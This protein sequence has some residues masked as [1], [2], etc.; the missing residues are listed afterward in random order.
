MLPSSARGGG[1]ENCSKEEAPFVWTYQYIITLELIL[2][3]VWGG[4]GYYRGMEPN[5]VKVNQISNLPYLLSVHLA[6]IPRELMTTL[7][8]LQAFSLFYIGTVS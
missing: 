6:T 5:N 8:L 2:K 7:P 4:G 1:V 3:W